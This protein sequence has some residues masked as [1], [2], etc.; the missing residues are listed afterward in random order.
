MPGR[1]LRRFCFALLVVVVAGL[2]VSRY[3]GV[4][5]KNADGRVFGYSAP[6]QEWLA[7][8][9]PNLPA[10]IDGPYVLG[11]ADTREVVRLTRT[12]DATVV[13]HR[14]PL[15]AG[16]I[17]V[18]TDEAL[19]RRFRVALRGAHPRAPVELPM[20][21]RLLIASDFEG[22]FDAFTTLMQA[23]GVIDADWHW[24]F[25][26]GRVVLV[27]DMVD[28]GRNV[29]PLLWLVYRLEAEAAAAGG[30][31]HYVLGNHEQ[32]LLTGRISDAHE[33]YTGTLRLLD[34]A[35]AALWNER[36]E[37]GR[38]L[39]SKPVLLKV[40]DLLFMH[41]GLSPEVLALRPTLTEVDAHAAA[42]FAT[43]PADIADARARAVLWDRTGVLWYRGLA[44]ALEG[45]PRADTAH[46]DA[47]RRHFGVNRLAIGHTLAR[48]VGQ[49]YDG[50]L[51]RIDVHHASGTTEGV[52]IENGETW[53][54]DAA[55]GRH[56]LAAAVN[57]DD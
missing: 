44:M 6:T 12:S 33:K 2:G 17:E 7:M 54:I 52:L 32:K 39:R 26:D 1:W 22:E 46:L 3:R 51:L 24:N 36:S 34:T 16:E 40:G 28:R 47:V 14:A 43:P 41:G 15:S 21:G 10:A 38:W 50:K 45:M 55:G 18:E 30:G 35:P 29:V 48:A 5:L 53:R 57:L 37:L 56:P 13:V 25:G 20:P 19:P 9:Y 4:V 23:H 11:P 31:M 42:V 27:G 8:Q 49:D